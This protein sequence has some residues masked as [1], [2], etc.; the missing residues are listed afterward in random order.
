MKLK[1]LFL[2][3]EVKKEK[4]ERKSKQESGKR[5]QA[6]DNQSIFSRDD[7]C[8]I[9]TL[10]IQINPFGFA[11]HF[12]RFHVSGKKNHLGIFFPGLMKIRTIRDKFT[13]Y[14]ALN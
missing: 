7:F 5:S 8:Q 4:N 12:S 13:N 9:F 2:F 6:V 1:K 11:F 14:Y 3:I 10:E